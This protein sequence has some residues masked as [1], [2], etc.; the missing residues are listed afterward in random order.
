[1][2]LIEKWRSEDI[3]S[4]AFILLADP[5]MGKTAIAANLLHYN[6]LA[7][8]GVFCEWDKPSY[9][10]PK[11]VVKTL[12]FK[13]STKLPDYRKLLLSQ[14][15]IIKNKIDTLSESELFDQL[16]SI[17]LNHLIDGARERMMIIID[18][19]DE[20]IQNN[21]NELV[22]LLSKEMHKLP[23]WLCFFITSRPAIKV[24]DFMQ[25]FNPI[26][27]SAETEN[28]MSDIR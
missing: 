20:A 16:L 26:Y 13:L 8:A 15:G 3:D 22:E 28:N 27:L 23:K 1:M 14:I 4:R 24:L 7:I 18:G 5:G 25:S 6:N 12:S 19:L 9:N 10:N 17:P 11:N 2:A 21:P